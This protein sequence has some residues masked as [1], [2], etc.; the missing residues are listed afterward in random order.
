MRNETEMEV[1]QD[2][3]TERWRYAIME[4]YIVGWKMT[5]KTFVGKRLIGKNRNKK[6]TVRP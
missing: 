4:S 2:M 5:K 6:L 1:V 3:M